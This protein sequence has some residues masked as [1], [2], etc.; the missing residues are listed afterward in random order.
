METVS[1][2]LG[3]R[4]MCDIQ[5]HIT[6]DRSKIRAKY[7]FGAD[8]G[9]SHIARSFGFNFATTPGGPKAC[10][11]L[12]R[13]EPDH[14]F[15]EKKHA[16]IHW[17]IQLERKS[18]PGVVANLRVVRPWNEW[19]VVAFGP[20]GTNPFESFTLESVEIID[21]VRGLVGDA[22]ID[23]KVLQLDPWTVRESVAHQYSNSDN[24]VFLI[25]DAA[26]RH[27]PTFG[28]GSNTCIQDAYNLA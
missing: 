23:V 6:N 25:G 14:L 8:G 12:I 18:F 19:V 24:S 10:N 4:Y 28:L 3:T 16:G 22:A 27:P 15:P 1:D 11:I 17:L 2:H 20:G 26:H 5:D 7:I 9:R 21:F 13:A